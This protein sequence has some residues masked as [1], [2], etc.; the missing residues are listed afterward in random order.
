MQKETQ[1]YRIEL[2]IS[3]QEDVE[4]PLGGLEHNTNAGLCEAYARIFGEDK[5]PS[6]FFDDTV[7]PVEVID[8]VIA[9]DEPV[10]LEFEDSVEDALAQAEE[11]ITALVADAVNRFNASGMIGA[12]NYDGP[13]H[14]EEIVKQYDALCELKGAWYAIDKCG[15]H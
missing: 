5:N 6:A 2:K 4:P 3:K 10:A 7:A 15:L 13:S 12:E 8:G 9:V 1:V 11:N 14:F